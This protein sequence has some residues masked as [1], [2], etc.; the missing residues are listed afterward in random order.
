MTFDV[1]AE[2]A[3]DGDAIR[4][5]GTVDGLERLTEFLIHRTNLRLSGPAL[6]R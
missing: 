5:D 4:G 2:R 1:Q 3:L 6:Q